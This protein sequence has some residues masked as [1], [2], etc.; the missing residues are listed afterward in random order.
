MLMHGYR[1]Q[2]RHGRPYNEVCYHLICTSRTHNELES[3]KSAGANE[4]A[5]IAFMQ[6]AV[7]TASLQLLDQSCVSHYAES[8]RHTTF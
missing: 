2:R 4:K 1:T 7:Q 8:G 3:A 6:G 5:C